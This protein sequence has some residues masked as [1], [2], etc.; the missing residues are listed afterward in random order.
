M[1]RSILVPSILAL[2]VATPFLFSKSNTK[3]TGLG[4]GPGNYQAQYGGYSRGLSATLP[5]SQNF[6]NLQRQNGANPFHQANATLG[7]NT[8]GSLNSQSAPIGNPGLAALDNPALRQ[9]IA[10]TAIAPGFPNTQPIPMGQPIPGGLPA[11]LPGGFSGQGTQP[12]LSQW[13]P[14]FGAAQTF[15]LPGNAHG[16]D[17]NA[18]P[19][20]FLPVTNF[21]EIFRFDINPT[22]IKQRWKRVSTSPGERDFHG[23]RVALITGTN[24]W[25]LHGSLTYYLDT[26][27]RVQRITFRGWTG[28][29]TKVVSLLTQ[30][31]QFRPQ[32]T[33]WAGFYI[34]G[35]KRKTTGGLLMQHPTVIQTDNPV[36][37]VAIV[38]EIN[39]PSGK[40]VLSHDFHSLI[41]GSLSTR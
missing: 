22:W 41:E 31:Y 3:R 38:L 35:T 39:N 37:Q 14:D 28:D 15:V 30:R 27:Q 21:E 11:G 25:D 9:P 1:L 6:G 4:T 29:S 26:S 20:E 36:Q 8:N 10:A 7:S 13:T 23:L 2:I 34:A 33:H 18:Q 17:L 12:D 24:S 40:S 5:N 19:L 16:P 32:Q